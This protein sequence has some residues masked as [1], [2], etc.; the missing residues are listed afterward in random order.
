MGSSDLVCDPVS[1][2]CPCR[3]GVVTRTCSRCNATYYDFQSGQGCVECK[4]NASGS[5]DLQCD[6]VSGVCPCKNST[7]GSKCDMC[8]KNFFNFTSEGCQ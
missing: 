7:T 5:S 6:D 4:C 8:R 2:Q 1:G 3:P